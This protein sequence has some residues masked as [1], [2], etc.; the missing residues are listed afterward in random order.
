[1]LENALVDRPKLDVKFKPIS[2]QYFCYFWWS[3]MDNQPV[4]VLIIMI[5]A[6]DTS[7]KVEYM[8]ST[9]YELT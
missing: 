9:Y 5:V 3:W 6:A 1:M 8:Q 4:I 7:L 2:R